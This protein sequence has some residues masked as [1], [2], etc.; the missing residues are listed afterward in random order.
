MCDASR[1]DAA[2]V[3]HHWLTQQ[4]GIN[5]LSS[6]SVWC[7][8]GKVNWKFLF[9]IWLI[10][11]FVGLLSTS[12][13]SWTEKCLTRC[14]RVWR[15]LPSQNVLCWTGRGDTLC[16][17][18]IFCCTQHL[19]VLT[20]I[21]LCIVTKRWLVPAQPQIISGGCLIFYCNGSHTRLPRFCNWTNFWF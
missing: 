15:N 10:R 1:Y 14:P 8:G 20:K 4:E 3:V 17:S 6:H 19:L 2:L 21:L 12:S 18:L 16:K 13:R 5:F 7:V 9:F 11:N